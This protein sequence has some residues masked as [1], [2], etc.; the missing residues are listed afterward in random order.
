MNRL[1]MG[2]VLLAVVL[3]G[4]AWADA[5]QDFAN[6]QIVITVSPDENLGSTDTVMVE[7]SGFVPSVMVDIT[8]CSALFG[9][10]VHGPTEIICSSLRAAVLSDPSGHFGP[11]A[12][13]VSRTFEG[14]TGGHEPQAATHT[15]EPT[16]DCVFY[17][18]SEASQLR[19]GYHHLD[20]AP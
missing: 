19:Y 9:E 3:V 18:I 8:E 6:A 20:F 13:P 5:P 17:V 2:C 11:V 4:P 12:V 10:D 1:S 15:C 7:G 16:G 14:T